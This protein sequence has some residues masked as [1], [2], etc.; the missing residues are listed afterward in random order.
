[1]ILSLHLKVWE[2]TKGSSVVCSAPTPKT[3]L[4]TLDLTMVLLVRLPR[5]PCLVYKHHS[6][7]VL[8]V[9]AML[10]VL[11][12]SSYSPSSEAVTWLLNLEEAFLQEGLLPALTQFGF[13]SFG[14]L[15][16]LCEGD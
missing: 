3:V 4:M 8:S 12:R 10:L 15:C 11:E 14:S 2:E 6:S 7:A 5:Y 1:M 16:L 9:L 13:F